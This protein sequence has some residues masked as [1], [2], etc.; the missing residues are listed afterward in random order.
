MSIGMT[1]FRELYGYESPSF[2]Q[3]KFGERKAPKAIDW[4]QESHDILRILKE[5]LQVF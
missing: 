2:V 5:N 1:Q 3:L 4:L